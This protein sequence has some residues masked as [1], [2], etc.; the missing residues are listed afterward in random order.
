M[1]KIIK[2]MISKLQAKKIKKRIVSNP[3]AAL[4]I[5]SPLHGNLGDHAI[6]LGSRSFIKNLGYEDII[7]IPGSVV[8]DNIDYIVKNTNIE[9]DIFIIGGGFMGSLW[10]IEQEMVE[11]AVNSFS[12]NNI[13]FLPQTIFFE[14]ES[15]ENDFVKKAGNV[16]NKDDIIFFAR[17]RSSVENAKKYGFKNVYLGIDLVIPLISKYEYDEKINEKKENILL[18]FRGDK[19]KVLSNRIS[20]IINEIINKYSLVCRNT[21][22]VVNR[23]ISEMNRLKEVNSKLDEFHKS[24]IVITDRLHGMIFAFIAKKPC[25]V[26]DNVSKKVSGVYEYLSNYTNYIYLVDEMNLI[27]VFDKVM[28]QNKIIYYNEMINS[29]IN[30][31]IKI[32]KTG[33]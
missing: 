22:T 14:N 26:F 24:D 27:E 4:L 12:S 15:L 32:I 21:D 31:M 33:K 1:K 9:N 6:A 13:V 18:C 25:L 3:D 7:E 30:K 16:F 28:Q 5:G 10:P 2:K 29:D 20:V 23:R 17:D 11:K 8:V 19:E